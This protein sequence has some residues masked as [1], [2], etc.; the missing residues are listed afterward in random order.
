M[1]RK[2]PL[3]LGILCSITSLFSQEKVEKTSWYTSPDTKGYISIQKIDSVVGN[4]AYT[5][6]KT[7]VKASFDNEVLDFSLSTINDTDKMVSPS[8]FVF[9]GTID[10]NIKPVTFTGTLIKKDKKNV[11][12]WSFDGDFTDEMETDPDFKRFA[13]AKYSAT[14]RIP[15]RT[16]PSFNLWAIVPNLKFDRKG[17]FKFNSLDETKLYVKKGQTVNYL[18]K[19]KVEI[20]GEVMVLHKFVQQSNDKNPTYYWV[21]NERDLVQILLDDKYTF[22]INSKEAAI[23]ALANNNE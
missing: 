9:D 17:T 14:L 1:K 15:E 21:N 10:S 13:Y 22:T 2:L 11:A 20:N 18:G 8:K 7:T 19:T 6:L 16:I 5:I 4:K 3:M 12:Y 23:T